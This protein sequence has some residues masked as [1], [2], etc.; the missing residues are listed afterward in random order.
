MLTFIKFDSKLRWSE[1]EEG[2]NVSVSC[3]SQQWPRAYLKEA[4][5]IRSTMR[6]HDEGPYVA[7]I[8][9]SARNSQGFDTQYIVSLFPIRIN[10]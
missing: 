5:F 8:D 1:S 3:H 4:K 10:S 2:A 6:A 9:V 7:D